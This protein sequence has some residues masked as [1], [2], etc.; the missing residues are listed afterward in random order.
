MGDACVKE[1]RLH[2]FFRHTLVFDYRVDHFA[3]GCKRIQNFGDE[4]GKEGN[5]S[6]WMGECIPRASVICRELD[7]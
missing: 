7:C 3:F 2:R 6:A 1:Y 5:Q 4:Q